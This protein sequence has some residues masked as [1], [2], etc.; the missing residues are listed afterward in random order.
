MKRPTLA[1]TMCLRDE[2][3]YLAYHLA[4]HHAL[5]VSRGYLFLDRCTDATPAV[6][7]SFPW[8]QTIRQD[9]D[10]S[11]EQLASYQRRCADQALALARREGIDW[12]L[13]LDVDE[14]AWG[15]NPEPPQ[16]NRGGGQP[17]TLLDA[18]CLTTLLSR[19][20]SETVQIILRPRE[21]VPQPLRDEKAFWKLHWFQD[22]G[23]VERPLLDPVTGTV[24]RLDRWLGHRL[25]KSI[26]RTSASLEA[27][28]PHRWQGRDGAATPTECLGRHCHYVVVGAGHWLSKYRKLSTCPDRWPR[29]AP[30][31]FPKQSWKEAAA[32]WSAAEARR[33]FDDWVVMRPSDLE[34][35]QAEGIVVRD[36]TVECILTRLG[37][38]P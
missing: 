4:Y 38:L 21:A 24:R 20:Q 16:P 15:E 36:D 32:R 18:G 13:H 25:G 5:G 34:A 27:I 8:V 17:M 23:V 11:Q 12:L 26:V 14:F 37:V 35:G 7:R 29:G 30:V 28:D 1:M 33:Y 19:A 6:A 9:R 22:G 10:P 3:D 31:P 2:E